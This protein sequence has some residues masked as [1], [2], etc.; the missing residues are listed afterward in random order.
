M[1]TLGLIII[2]IAAIGLFVFNFMG[3]SAPPFII[4]LILMSGLSAVFFIL[5]SLLIKMVQSRKK[6]SL[7][8]LWDYYSR[9]QSSSVR[10][11][12]SKLRG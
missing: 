12:L 1:R 2:G 10:K 3:D 11:R 5:A 6:I 4:P 7:S 8:E 9:R